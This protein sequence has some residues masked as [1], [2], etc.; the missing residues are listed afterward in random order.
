MN[1]A[2]L[3]GSLDTGQL[4]YF[5]KPCPLLSLLPPK[6]TFHGVGFNAIDK[7]ISLDRTIRGC[8]YQLED[9]ILFWENID[10]SP[11]F[12]ADYQ[13]D[14]H[15]HIPHPSPAQAARTRH[16]L[17]DVQYT[18]LSTNFQPDY[19][20]DVG[21][22]ISGFC[23]I[24]LIV[25]SLTI[26]N[27]RSPVTSVGL[28]I[29]ET[30]RRVFT[31]LVSQSSYPARGLISPEYLPLPADFLLWAIFLTAS[32]MA[33]TEDRSDTQDWLLKS[34]FDLID[35]TKR[36]FH[37]WHGLKSYLSRYLWVSSLHDTSCRWLWTEM[38]RMRRKPQSLT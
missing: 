16:L 2:D 14:I 10:A 3:Y 37:D 11:S 9:A 12:A 36:D 23:R 17:T 33:T 21:D 15:N 18:L 4:P 5:N 32:V 7:H 30:F 27:E 25:F 38:E 6:V 13:S 29:G 1:R 20:G 26:L 19:R 24:T 31:D 22:R 28:Q 8:I 35:S 34:F